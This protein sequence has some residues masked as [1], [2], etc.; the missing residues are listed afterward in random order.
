[1][2]VAMVELDR[3]SLSVCSTR[4]DVVPKEI[5]GVGAEELLRR[6][7]ED[8]AVRVTEKGCALIGHIK[9]RAVTPDAPPLFF[10]ITRVG[11]AA[12]LKGGPLPPRSN[13]ELIVTMILA[14]L[15]PPAMR[16]ALQE[17]LEE[18][19]ELTGDMEE[20]GHAHEH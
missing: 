3:D 1:M 4:A 16:Q 5:S 14:A 7:L 19:F 9:G 11:G 6:F 20:M 17:S 18:F 13:W 12:T 8:L 10:S 15:E 2:D